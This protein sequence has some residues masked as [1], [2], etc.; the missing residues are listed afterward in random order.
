MARNVEAVPGVASV[1]TVSHLPMD[2]NGSLDPVFAEDRRYAEGEIAPLRRFKYI[3]PD[4][5]RTMGDPILAGRDLTWKD[6]H[7][8][9]PVALMS[10]NLAREYWGMRAGCNREAGSRG[11]PA[12]VEARCSAWPGMSVPRAEQA[13]PT[14]VYGP[15]WCKSSTAPTILRA[16]TMNFEIRRIARARQF[17]ERYST[18]RL[19][20]ESRIAARDVR[21][22]RIFIAGRWR[23]VPSCW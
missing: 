7:E 17:D 1:R 19:G 11:S 22:R 12:A 4:Y 14:T 8:A 20:G 3:S 16:P 13:A 23:G 21:T 9:A 15:G 6:I 2:N 5:F 18:G 10:E